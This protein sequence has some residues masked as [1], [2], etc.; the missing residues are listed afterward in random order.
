MCVSLEINPMIRPSSHS[1]RIDYD[2]LVH[3]EGSV[4]CGFVASGFFF[5]FRCILT[6]AWAIVSCYYAVLL[7][8]TCGSP[9]EYT[10]KGKT[11]RKYICTCVNLVLA[12]YMYPVYSVL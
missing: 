10:K 11:G 6:G 1:H 9:T 7:L 4:L 5:L 8:R 12:N 2:W 3:S